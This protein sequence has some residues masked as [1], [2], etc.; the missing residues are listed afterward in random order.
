[1]VNPAR[2]V[3][4]ATQ[5]R[6]VAREFFLFLPGLPLE[7][8]P[9]F[10][11]FVRKTSRGEIAGSI[12]QGRT[13]RDVDARIHNQRKTPTMRRR[14]R[15]AGLRVLHVSLIVNTTPRGWRQIE[16]L[17]PRMASRTLSPV[18][19]PAVGGVSVL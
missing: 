16:R 1:M 11:R 12:S 13:L 7:R 10:P 3:S 19:L 17:L 2:L 15:N 18:P 5:R 4:V 14:Q 8:S 9:L 6:R